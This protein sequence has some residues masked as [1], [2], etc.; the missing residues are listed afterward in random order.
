MQENMLSVGITDVCSR[1]ILRMLMDKACSCY[2]PVN[3]RKR[4]L[5]NGFNTFSHFI[6]GLFQQAYWN[7][8]DLM[9][10]RMYVA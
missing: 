6:T 5:V 4:W 10:K 9:F 8:G 1:E 7:F 2:I 3:N